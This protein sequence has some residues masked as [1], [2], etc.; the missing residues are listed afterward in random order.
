M[1]SNKILYCRHKI[2][3]SRVCFW[4][5]VLRTWHPCYNLQT[6]NTTANYAPLNCFGGNRAD[7]DNIIQEQSLPG[8]V[9]GEG[10]STT[11]NALLVDGNTS[12]IARVL[13]LERNTE[14]PI[15][16]TVTQTDYHKNGASPK[17]RDINFK[18]PLWNCNSITIIQQHLDIMRSTYKLLAS[19]FA[20]LWVTFVS[21][22]RG[23]HRAGSS[24]LDTRICH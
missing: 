12:L 22:V 18:I 3:A 8:E 5:S 23:F 14:V 7:H 19:D 13:L 24:M 4:A 1:Q 20:E 21:C 9:V 15:E 6:V 2:W 11:S 10:F 16:Y 17:S